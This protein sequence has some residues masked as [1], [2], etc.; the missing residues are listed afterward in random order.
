M[1]IMNPATMLPERWQDFKDQAI[2]LAGRKVDL[3]APPSAV[4]VIRGCQ[5]GTLSG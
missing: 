4:E 5:C 3:Q 2:M 1:S